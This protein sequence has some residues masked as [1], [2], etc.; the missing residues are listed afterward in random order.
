[1]ISPVLCTWIKQGY[2]CA[3]GRIWS[4]GCR[5]FAET[6]GGTGQTQILG[7]STAVK[8]NMLNVHGL[9]DDVQACLT[10]CA[11]VRCVVVDEA[12]KSSL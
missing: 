6:A 9:A 1:M 5:G 7:R 2:C 10:V 12:C 4:R 8:I 3:R 11:V